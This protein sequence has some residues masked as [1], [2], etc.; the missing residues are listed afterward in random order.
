MNYPD[1]KLNIVVISDGSDDKTD[2]I[3]ESFEDVS[4]FKTGERVGKAEAINRF[5]NTGVETP[6]VVFS[7]ANSIYDP[8]ALKAL[9]KHFGDDRIGLVCGELQYTE[10]VTDIGRGESLYWKYEKF[11][12]KQESKMGRLLSP[13]GCIYAIRTELFKP[14]HPKAMSDF[15]MAEDIAIQNRDLIYEPGAVVRENTCVPVSEEFNRKQR[16][17]A[18]C[19]QV[20]GDKFQKLEIPRLFQ[21]ISHKLIRWLVPFFLIAVLILNL[22]LLDSIFYRFLLVAQILF[23]SFAAM[24]WLLYRFNFNPFGVFLYFIVVNSASAKGVI[25]FLTD[26]HKATWESPESTRDKK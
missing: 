16:I 19:L 12:R 25:K 5:F 3:V 4:L 24:G 23:Y 9:M 1:E 17:I 13:N 7:D 8:D 20:V 2:K 21:M 11:I 15:Q 26:T 22:F 14:L 10:P 6:F 18:G